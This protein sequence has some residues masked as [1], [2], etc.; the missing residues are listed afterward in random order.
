LFLHFVAHP[1][2]MVTLIWVSF[3]LIITENSAIDMIWRFLKF[4]CKI[5]ACTFWNYWKKCWKGW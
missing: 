5:E 2:K 1:I 3:I 4:S